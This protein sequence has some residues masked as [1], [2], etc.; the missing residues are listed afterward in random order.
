MIKCR[1]NWVSLFLL[2]SL[3]MASARADVCPCTIWPSAAMPLT[4]SVSDPAGVEVGIKFKADTDGVITAIRFYKGSTNT[5]AHVGSLWG[6]NGTRLGTAAFTD[7][8]PSGWQQASFAV[9]VRVT[10]NTTYIASYYAPNGNY[11]AT[12]R[13]F[14]MQGVDRPPLHAYR[15]GVEGGN[16]VYAYA[17]QS[18]LPTSTYADTNYWV[19]VVFEP[20]AAEPE[21]LP[22][23]APILVVTSK[24][25][26]F[27]QYYGEILHAEGLNEFAMA[28]LSVITPA[29]LSER[30]VVILGQMPLTDT[31]VTMLSDWVNAGGNLI[32][33]RPDKKLAGL[34][35]L[36]D[37]AA[38]LG[39]GYL[40]V[41]PS[42]PGLGIV[43][44]TIQFH[45]FA[46]R[47][48]LGDAAAVAT[49]YA[50][51]ATA[52]PNP[53]VSLRTVGSNNGHAAAFTYDLAKSVVYTRQGNPA[54]AG[55]ER[56]GESLI[57]PDDLLVDYLDMA[58]VAIPQAD[59]QQRL[60]ANLITQINLAK[61]PLPRFW[62]LPSGLK[63]AI[64]HTLD[65]HGT[66]KGTRTTFDSLIANSPPGCSVADWQCLRA[67]A[68]VY[69][70]IPLT[71]AEAASYQTAGFEM[72]VHVQH[73]P[74]DFVSFAD[75]EATYADQMGTFQRMFPSVLPQTTHRYHA[76]L[77]SDWLSQAKAARVH[78]IRY[79]MDYYFW[80]PAWAQGRRGLL[81][82]SGIPM[83]FADT[84]GSILD[85]YQG[86]SDLVNETIKVE[87]VQA[88]VGAINTLLDR[89][90]GP[91]GYY[92]L[93]GTH[94]DFQDEDFLPAVI[95][96]AT[97]HRVPVIGAKQALTWLDGR[98][99][100]SFS[101]FTWANRRLGFT[102]A[103]A[104]GARN[105][106]AMLPLNTLSHALSTITRDGV[107][108]SF[109]TQTIKG[110]EYAFF[111]AVA[112]TYAA[113]Y[114]GSIAPPP[115][116]A[117]AV[118]LWPGSTVPAT[119]S[120]PDASP[121]ELGVRFKSE[122][123]GRVVGLR[124]YKGEG[125]TGT[126]V[127]NLWTD[128]GTRLATAPFVN[129]RAT[130]W[131]QVI[132]A[133]PVSIAAD[134]TYVASYHT[135]TGHYALNPD[136]F[137]AAGVDSPPLHAPP[138]S[139]SQHNGVFASGTSAFPS[140]S[141]RATNYWVDVVFIETATAALSLWNNS[142]IPANA[143]VSDPSAVE[144]GMKF[145]SDV[146][147]KIR[148]IRFYKGP[149]NTGTHTATLWTQT[150]SPLATATFIDETT[151]GWQE[152]RFTTP[153]DIAANTTYV[154]SYY[155]PA[156]NYAVNAG[157]FG[158][159]FDQGVLHA[160]P[161]GTSQGN[162]VYRYGTS[163]FPESTFNANNYWVD[164]LF[165][166]AP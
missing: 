2:F 49:L 95:S 127:A 72:G 133:S 71:D 17:S 128:T 32:A 36:T 35:G 145:R 130:G 11:A 68:W 28:D 125:N 97:S 61:K 12:G 8:T 162:G 124:F 55:K 34:L 151:T 91:E 115:V 117:G 120:F 23:P 100:S 152:V 94:D 69:S 84:D 140:S 53:A 136:Y 156:G 108:V 118:T 5:G 144:L 4:A 6:A 116:P 88:Y 41:S 90:L 81:T 165:E 123:A 25:N 39:D 40:L 66:T 93:F 148:G 160:L 37:A 80:P 15:S 60:L 70:N 121:Y 106:Q 132:F 64:V 63:A 122:R 157:Y 43:N 139:A 112:G 87:G 29:I 14:E 19:D 59:E 166:P 164:V 30:D 1:A 82:G 147:G 107:S 50:D 7:E 153:V 65:D 54:F 79:S 143:A 44:Q 26:R 46:D 101:A 77:W 149:G 56:D 113:A 137:A 138:D 73:A 154:A 24:A 52:T 57:R 146:A 62:Y 102:V 20:G 99:G 78:D 104:A 103:A 10:A 111:P 16:G 13:Y 129:E 158:A 51:A 74:M 45:D 98:N 27:T 155:A 92:G 134:T 161:S 109:T 85:V 48:T 3:Q 22:G 141:S 21:P 150:G 18:R 96:S 114:D 67:T 42:G 159:G 105:L 33:M 75:V 76:I 89:A 83:R 142:T 58:K 86:T 163:G 31:Q 126:H 135:D 38:T 47:Y 9:P 131:Q 119:A 110:I